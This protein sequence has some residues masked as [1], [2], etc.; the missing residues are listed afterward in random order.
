MTNIEFIFAGDK[1]FIEWLVTAKY[2]SKRYRPRRGGV[3]LP[4]ILL[5]G[6]TR[7]Y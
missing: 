2:L 7:I 6:F 3:A 4:G 1:W 5:W